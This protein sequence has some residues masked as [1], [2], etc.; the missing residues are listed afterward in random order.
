MSKRTFQFLSSDQ[1][2]NIHAVRW[3]PDEGEIKG[4]LQISHGMVEYIERYEEFAE[5]MT[6]ED[7]DKTPAKWLKVALGKGLITWED[8]ENTIAFLLGGGFMN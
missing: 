4:I 8:I 7:F 6:K 2:T 3:E 5:F 1:T